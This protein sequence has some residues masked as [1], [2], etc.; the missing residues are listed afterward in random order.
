MLNEFKEY[1]FIQSFNVNLKE[2]ILKLKYKQEFLK[3]KVDSVKRLEDDIRCEEIELLKMR[4][5]LGD[6]ELLEKNKETIEELL[7]D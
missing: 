5:N 4:Q 1:E 3:S 7:E 2:N 6:V